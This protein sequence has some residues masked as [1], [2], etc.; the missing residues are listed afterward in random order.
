MK[1][2]VYLVGIL[3]I[4]IVSVAYA[5]NVF[6]ADDHTHKY[7]SYQNYPQYTTTHHRAYCT[8]SGCYKYQS[9]P[10]EY[11][12]WYTTSYPS[13]TSTGT[14]ERE[15]SVCGA[16]ETDTLSAYG[17]SY[18]TQNTSSTY[19]KSAATCTSAAVYYYKCSRCSSYSTS[20]TYTSGSANGH[21]Y[22]E[23]IIT[24]AT[25][26]ETGVKEYT[27]SVCS[28]SYTETIEATGHNFTQTCPLCG[29]E[30]VVCSNEGCTEVS[31]HTCDQTPPEISFGTNGS[32][33]IS[34]KAS[35]V[36]TI[37]DVSE[38]DASSLKYLWTESTTQPSES[39]FTESFINGEEI[40]TSGKTGTYYLW[41]LAKD[42]AGNTAIAMSGSFELDGEAPEGV[43]SISSGFEDDGMKYTNTHNLT[44]TFSASDNKSSESEMQIALI[45]ENEFSL[46]NPNSE[47]SWQDFSE[48]IEWTTS[49]GD[50]LKRIYVIFK[51][52]A[53]NQSLYLAM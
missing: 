50:G 40:T 19:L 48:S 6:A 36:V 12:S 27:C 5:M 4:C 20:K 14:E 11:G 15:C 24:A 34:N 22:N 49:A 1:K 39:S 2:K 41:I 8:V 25:C 26:T 9:A 43:M 45:N 18:T 46:T 53:G 30:N 16:T 33:T 21:S 7:G 47:I 37:T 44:L 42:V 51:D 10:H 38:I 52:A 31:T 13:C 32:T 23:E 28:D 29:T 35:T 17:H 3:I